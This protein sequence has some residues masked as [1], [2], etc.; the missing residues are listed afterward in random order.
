MVATDLRVTCSFMRSWVRLTVPDQGVCMTQVDVPAILLSVSFG[1]SQG[2]YQ[3]FSFPI[4]N[5]EI[6]N[7]YRVVRI[8]EILH[9][10]E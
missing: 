5:T 9:M 8:C 7:L 10:K 6:V 1:A 4:C 2:P 3:D